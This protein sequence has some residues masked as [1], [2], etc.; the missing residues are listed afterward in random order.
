MRTHR[1]QTVGAQLVASLIILLFSAVAFAG[2][3]VQW[4]STAIK[5]RTNKSWQL[6]LTITLAKTPD[7]SNLPMKFEFQ[8]I[9]YFERSMVDGDKLVERA[10]PLEGRQ[11]MIESVDVGFMDPGSGKVEKRTRFSFKLTRARGYESGEYKVTI[12]DGRSGQAIG[13]PQTIKL[14]GENEIID[15]RAIVFTGE[16]KKKPEGAKSAEE[17]PAGDESKETESGDKAE[18]TDE[19]ADAK[20]DG[21]EEDDAKGPDTNNEEEDGDKSDEMEGA[22]DGRDDD[23][24]S[25]STIKEKPGT[26]GCRTVG[27][28]AGGASAGLGLLA[29]GLVLAARRRHA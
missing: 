25:P 21:G 29:L 22:S 16:K 6:E 3:R 27:G 28:G 15:R 8:P 11:P 9:T 18:S 5:E 2:G 7:F 12:K 14:E 19:K 24:D 4:K 17:K 26:C 13:T 10:V 23:D 20:S 1:T